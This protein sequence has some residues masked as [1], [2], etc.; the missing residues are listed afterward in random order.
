MV[1]AEQPVTEI[2]TEL[3]AQA[4]AA[5]DRRREAQR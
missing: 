2:L 3:I 1:R 4:E 5:L